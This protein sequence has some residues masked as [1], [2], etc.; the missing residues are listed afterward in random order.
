MKRTAILVLGGLTISSPLIAGGI[1]DG[2]A[3][4][5]ALRGGQYDDAVRLFTK[6]LTDKKLSKNDQE[7]A[8]L[9]R[10]KALL[11]QRKLQEAKTDL[12]KAVALNPDDLDAKATLSLVTSGI[13]QPQ[14][15]QSSAKVPSSLPAP[16]AIWG[17]YAALAG[18][19]WIMVDKEPLGYFYVSWKE[20]DKKLISTGLTKTG[21]KVKSVMEIDK[22]TGRLFSID[23][24]QG[25]PR[26]R[27]DTTTQESDRSISV[28]DIKG[29][30]IRQ[31]LTKVSAAG[32]SL[33]TEFDNGTGWKVVGSQL[34]FEGTQENIAALGWKARPSEWKVLMS[35]MLE[36]MKQGAMEGAREG[37]RGGA[38]QLSRKINPEGKPK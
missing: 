4:I 22:K 36:A 15:L 33:M 31:T 9:G 34:L 10:G 20:F 16:S 28:G 14:T 38:D 35:G 18:H 25:M 5:T 32:Y 27:L 19:A 13:S 30:P 3:G 29:H 2:T 8:Y 23:E 6:A 7:L 21:S 26:I 17:P 12:I 24:T 11:A 1:E 37:I